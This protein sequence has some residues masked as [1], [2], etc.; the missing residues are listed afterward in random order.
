MAEKAT[1]VTTR[2][3]LFATH[4]AND[5]QIQTS[6]WDFRLLFA[7]IQGVDTA[8]AT[9]EVEQV[10]D[11][12]MSPQLAKRVAAILQRQVDHYERTIGPIPLA[13]N[14]DDEN[15]LVTVSEQ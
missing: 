13:P 12:R 6:P 14:A 10:A 9:F 11:V 2:S 15:E 4:Y 5:V 1:R 8:T 3:N 7:I